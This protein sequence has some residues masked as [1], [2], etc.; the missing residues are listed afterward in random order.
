M[1]SLPVNSDQIGILGLIDLFFGVLILARQHIDVL[2]IRWHNLCGR[3]V[4]FTISRHRSFSIACH[5]SIFHKQL[6]VWLLN[7]Q[8]GI[9]RTTSSLKIGELARTWAIQAS[10]GVELRPGVRRLSVFESAWVRAC[11]LFNQYLVIR[12]WPYSLLSWLS[13][14]SRLGHPASKLDQFWRNC[15][16]RGLFAPCQS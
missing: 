14:C 9:Y 8:H 16:V 3:S 5:S 12:S 11:R 6:W 7:N 15:S 13:R 10:I 2:I 4:D 1:R